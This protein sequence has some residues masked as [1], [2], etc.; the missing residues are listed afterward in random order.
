M[1]G[2]IG[3]PFALASRKLTHLNQGIQTI[4]A[5][6]SICFGIWYGYQAM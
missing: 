3:L 1:S 2:M 5:V 6:L 4:A